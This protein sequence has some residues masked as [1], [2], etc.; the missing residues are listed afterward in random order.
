M[1]AGVTIMEG[2]EL[3][4]VDHDGRNVTAVNTDLGPIR[5][6]HVTFAC[7]VWA[8]DVWRMLGREF[9][10][11]VDGSATPLVDLVKAQEGDFTLARI[12]L[13]AAAG[14]EA[15]S[16]ISTRTSRCAARRTGTC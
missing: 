1:A 14:R 16:S 8:R 3:L 9:T 5:C 7:G 12:G 2:V 11:K 10:V 4:G 6:E 15:P 13:Q